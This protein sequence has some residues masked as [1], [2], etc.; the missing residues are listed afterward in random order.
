M[1][2]SC[3]AEGKN[4]KKQHSKSIHFCMKPNNRLLKELFFVL[5]LIF[6][7]SR[8]KIDIVTYRLKIKHLEKME[9]P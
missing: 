4:E 2:T 3:G 8:F 7:F 1:G 9:R 5:V 6:V